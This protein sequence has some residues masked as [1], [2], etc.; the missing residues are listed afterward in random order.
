MNTLIAFSLSAV[1]MLVA[2]GLMRWQKRTGHGVVVGHHIWPLTLIPVFQALYLYS[3]LGLMN[4]V[5]LAMGFF[6]GL[7][8]YR[9]RERWVRSVL[10]GMAICF[11]FGHFLSYF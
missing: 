4:G 3:E 9:Y 10:E 6:F 2:L 5:L 8:A 11:S 7:L 1:L